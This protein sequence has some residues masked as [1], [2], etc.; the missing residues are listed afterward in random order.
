[1]RTRTAVAIGLALWLAVPAEPQTPPTGDKSADV[2][3]LVN[4]LLGTLMGGAE[5]TEASLQAEVAEAGGVPFKRDVPLAFIGKA[6]L[7]RYLSELIDAEYP[8]GRARTD[9]RLLQAFDMLPR[10]TDLRK[11]RAR[12]LEENVA[13]FYDERPDRRRLYAVSEDRSFTP[14]N[15]IVLAHEL[16]HALQDQY[17]DLYAYLG[18]DVGD[19]DD[20]RIAWMSLL[21]GDA[22]L[23][24]ERFV[25]LR[26]GLGGAEVADASGSE[27]AGLGMPG[28]F[29]LPDA[30]PVVRDHLIQPYLTG[31]A[32]CRA[33]WARGG[34]A[35]VRD[36]WA[37]P[38]ASTEQVLHP[39]RYFAHEAPRSV[40]PRL[41]PPPGAW[42]LAE[43]TLGELL[44]RSLLEPG[45]EA[46]AEG[47]GGDGWRLY[48]SGS[49]TLLLWRSEWDTPAEARE[50][51]SA[52]V[53]RFERHGT[54]EKARNG[55]D[56]F[57]N[58]DG[59]LF[60]IRGSGDGVELVSGD[61]PGAVVRVVDA[62][63][64]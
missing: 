50:F 14:M 53:S 45:A 52:L 16:R 47:W 41:A 19:F 29:D 21:E 4:A 6:E 24:M 61:D 46:A 37:S 10:G 27:T 35:A 28:L 51:G 59:F 58:K 33:I 44:L 17:R 26:L 39:E 56:M 57:R 38:P 49:R 20:R 55:F 32:L 34:A 43:G 64:R 12:L 1:M 13:G 31:L 48:D 3:D 30:P 60:A 5:V 22:T 54:R 42:Q 18:D 7:S 8:T 23:V 2:S 40:T 9:E 62:A 15:Q 25:K 11:L 36:A 63:L